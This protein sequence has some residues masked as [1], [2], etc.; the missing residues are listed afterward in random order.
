MSEHRSQK[1][2]H[3]WYGSGVLTCHKGNTCLCSTSGCKQRGVDWQKGLHAWGLTSWRGDLSRASKS[4]QPWGS[5]QKNSLR[6]GNQDSKDV[7]IKKAGVLHGHL[8]ASSQK[9]PL[10]WTC[11]P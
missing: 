8:G 4:E 1:Q 5:S 7:P 2:A 10:A 9:Q 6:H 11:F 3:R